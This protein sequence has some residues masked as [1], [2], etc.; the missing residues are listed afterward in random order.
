MGAGVKRQ[1]TTWPTELAVLLLLSS[2]H[3]HAPGVEGKG[4]Q[5]LQARGRAHYRVQALQ[6][7]LALL[8]GGELAP[9]FE[10]KDL[11]LQQGLMVQKWY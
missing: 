10:T 7:F 3:V 9:K 11:D 1:Q 6:P 2:V 5:I 8:K 4:E